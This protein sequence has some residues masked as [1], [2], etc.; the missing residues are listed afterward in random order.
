MENVS[1]I[2]LQAKFC[3]IPPCLRTMPW[4]MPLPCPMHESHILGNSKVPE[5]QREE[6]REK[7][8][9]KRELH[10][11][12]T[13]VQIELEIHFIKILGDGFWTLVESPVVRYVCHLLHCKKAYANSSVV[14]K[15]SK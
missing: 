9:R 15:A 6:T 4:E 11:Q 8:S 2:G 5:L 12:K 3:N 7:M 14:Y 10:N 13:V 1:N